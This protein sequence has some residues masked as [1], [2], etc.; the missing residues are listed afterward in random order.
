MKITITRI[1][2][3]LCKHIIYYTYNDVNDNKT[4][5]ISNEIYGEITE[6]EIRKNI[7]QFK[8]TNHLA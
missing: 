7:K 8:K 1:R 5:Q 6:Q 2:T 3:L 4:N